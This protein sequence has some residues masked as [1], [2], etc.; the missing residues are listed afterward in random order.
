M[1]HTFNIGKHE[2]RIRM[3]LGFLLIGIAGF[4]ALSVWGTL[5]TFFLG[6]FAMYTGVHHFCPLW[7]LFGINT[8]DQHIEHH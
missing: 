1:D 4:T 2:R 5:I 7:K 8:C 3:W 6:I